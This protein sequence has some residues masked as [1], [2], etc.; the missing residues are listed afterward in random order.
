[1]NEKMSIQFVL[2][3]WTLSEMSELWMCD[4]REKKKEEED[5][6]ERIITL[7]VVSSNEGAS[8]VFFTPNKRF[9]SERV[10]SFVQYYIIVV[11]TLRCLRL[12]KQEEEEQKKVFSTTERMIWLS[13]FRRLVGAGHSWFDDCVN[14]LLFFN[15]PSKRPTRFYLFL[16]GHEKKKKRKKEKEKRFWNLHFYNIQ[17]HNTHTQNV[18]RAIRIYDCGKC[19]VFRV[20]IFAL[21]VR[22]NVRIFVRRGVRGGPILARKFCLLSNLFS[23]VEKKKEDRLPI[24]RDKIVNAESASQWFEDAHEREKRA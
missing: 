23:V 9:I 1:M 3:C 2:C 10:C 24:A 4:E 11:R 21:L 20:A 22:F 19:Y 12:R 8:T 16:C 5:K 7:P 6:E 18:Y 17:S 13:L 14:F 15:L